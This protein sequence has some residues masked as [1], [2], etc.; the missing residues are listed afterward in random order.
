MCGSV[1]AS[2]VGDAAIV[3]D[4]TSLLPPGGAVTDN[5]LQQLLDSLPDGV[6][7]VDRGGLVALANRAAS[8][9]LDASDGDGA[10][11][12]AP[13]PLPCERD[14]DV[15]LATPR[16]LTLSLRIA[17]TRFQDQPMRL[18]S[19]RDVTAQRQ[20]EHHR[21]ALR[22]A[23]RR[24]AMVQVTRTVAHEIRN[25][26]AVI[27]ANLAIMRDIFSELQEALMGPLNDRADTRPHRLRAALG[28]LR[29]ALPSGSRGAA[30]QQRAERALRDV[31]R[32]LDELG[33]LVE[34]LHGMID[35]G[36]IGVERMRSFLEEFRTMLGTRQRHYRELD[37]CAVAARACDLCALEVRAA[38]I[39]LTRSLAPVPAVVG[40]EFDLVQAIAALITNATAAIV[41]TDDS[42]S[43]DGRGANEDH[44]SD[45]DGPARALTS[46]TRRRDRPPG[47][48]EI[49]TQLVDKEILISVSDNGVGIS[50]EHQEH[51]F[52][53]LFL[54]D[55]D[56]S[57]LG[58]GLA[59]A[60]EIVADHGGSLAVES[61][62]GVGSRFEVRLPLDTGLSIDQ[63]PGQTPGPLRCQ[64]LMVH[65]DAQAG[66]A[67][68]HIL[69]PHYDV[70]SA[71]SGTDALTKLARD[72]DYDVLISELTMADMDGLELYR[73]LSLAMPRMLARIVFVG[74][75]EAID[76][77]LQ[78]VGDDQLRVLHTPLDPEQLLAA[79]ASICQR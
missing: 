26:A 58:F 49:A 72:R 52:D 28:A 38:E 35:D 39:V 24:A 41:A 8:S 16:P 50:E 4:A 5:V 27:L 53:P 71:T 45:G 12:G 56:G 78:L 66:A 37:V 10:L 57:V 76:E 3:S 79:V 69:A 48:I 18:L 64:V 74:N 13:C 46:A 42:D 6:L 55:P 31:D 22:A 43:S 54:P 40:D 25:P 7:V 29:E 51:I 63:G 2:R 9:L 68:A 61:Q 14:G 20:L 67:I 59:I 75:A 60:A 21:E 19:F 36:V 17:E 70:V 47:R 62:V 33:E 23:D 32:A 1:M 73:Q 77:L 15:Q 65:D 11:V 44:A 34:N 30:A